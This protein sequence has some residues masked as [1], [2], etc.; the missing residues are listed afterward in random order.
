MSNIEDDDLINV[1]G[2]TTI[3]GTILSSMV[4]LIEILYDAGKSTGSAIRRIVDDSL[5]P[6]KWFL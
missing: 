6:L 3:T 2:G 5:C 1:Y 4:N